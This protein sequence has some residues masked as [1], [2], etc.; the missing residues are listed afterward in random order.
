MAIPNTFINGTTADAD[1]VNDNFTYVEGE[2]TEAKEQMYT[3]TYSGDGTTSKAITGVGFEPTSISI[4]QTNGTLAIFG[5]SAI[6]GIVSFD[7]DGFTV[8]DQ[9]SNAEY[10]KDGQ[11]YIYTCYKNPA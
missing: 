4:A 1:E 6:D 8:T 7:A 3:G 5:T 2:I 11:N 9:G 10:N